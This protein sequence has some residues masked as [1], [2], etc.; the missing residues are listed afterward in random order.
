[1]GLREFSASRMMNVCIIQN[2][3]KCIFIYTFPKKGP[4]LTIRVNTPLNSLYVK[5]LQIVKT[6]NRKNSENYPNQA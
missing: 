4:V 1:M 5:E 2:R 3:E 6:K